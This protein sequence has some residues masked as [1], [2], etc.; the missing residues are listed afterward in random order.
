MNFQQFLQRNA[1][2]EDDAQNNQQDTAAQRQQEFTLF[3]SILVPFIKYIGPNRLEKM[4]LNFCQKKYN[5]NEILKIDDNTGRDDIT[6]KITKNKFTIY[7]PKAFNQTNESF[8]GFVVG[9][10][11][12]SLF[13]QI[14]AVATWFLEEPF[15]N[16]KIM[17]QTDEDR[18]SNDEQCKLNN[19]LDSTQLNNLKYAIWGKDIIER[20]KTNTNSLSG[21]RRIT[22]VKKCDKIPFNMLRPIGKSILCANYP[23]KGYT[24]PQ[25]DKALEYFC[26]N[27]GTKYLWQCL[28][29][30]HKKK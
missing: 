21:D 22:W 23:W 17:P 7:D 26:K 2:S 19:K 15:K 9:S 25:F 3:M 27:Y 10:L 6:I 1:L 24:N 20:L 13:A 4:L 5:L 14:K 11:I 8:I 18:K 29:R 12:K 16:F 30:A 28:M